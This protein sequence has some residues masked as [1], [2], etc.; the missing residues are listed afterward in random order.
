MIEILFQNRVPDHYTSMHSMGLSYT[1]TYEGS[2]Y[3]NTTTGGSP[4]FVEQE[5][6]PP[7]GCVIYKWLVTN[8]DGPPS[9]EP[10]VLR[11]YHPFVNLASD[12]DAGLVGPNIIYGRGLMENTM[13][14][15]REFIALFE[16]FD[17]SNS[18]VGKPPG[19]LSAPYAGNQSF[20]LPQVTNI[21]Q[22]QASA[23]QQS[24]QQTSQAT[25][26]AQFHTIN[27][28]VFGNNPPYEMCVDDNVI[29]YTMAYGSASHVFHL[30]GNN[31]LYDGRYIASKSINDG[32]MFTMYMEPQSPGV[33][34]LL[35]HVAMH[36]EMGMEALYQI[37]AKDEC[38]LAA[39]TVPKVMF[40]IA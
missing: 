40:P 32:E 15:Y 10:S 26:S 18:W 1:K 37:F 38:K 31:V 25:E 3:L 22:Q 2:D 28:Y 30:H 20:W 8:K 17:E 12:M 4:P 33:W 6:V 5:A 34:Q 35:C 23:Q 11:S 9:N 36:L 16:I 39:Q 24:S 7:G 27:G 29:W 21:V 19:Q 13:S 14:S